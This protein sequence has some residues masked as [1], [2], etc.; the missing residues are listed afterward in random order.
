[1]T[2]EGTLDSGKGRFTSSYFYCWR[3]FWPCSIGLG[4][5]FILTFVG[6][7]LKKLSDVLSFS[8]NKNFIDL[9]LQVLRGD[10]AVSCS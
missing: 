4:E 1:M 2:T 10:F 9:E 3:L 6:V 8:G 7:G 5:S